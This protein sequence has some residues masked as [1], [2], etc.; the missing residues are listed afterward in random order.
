[1]LEAPEVRGERRRRRAEQGG[2]SRRGDRLQRPDRAQHG[3]V[4]RDDLQP[5]HRPAQEVVREL[6]EDEQPEENVAA[7]RGWDA[8]KVRSRSILLRGRTTW[9]V[10]HMLRRIVL[11]SILI[12]AVAGTA[13]ASGAL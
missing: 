12:V 11:A 4:V 8:H 5:R 10:L 6:P 7:A 9:E 1:R 3:E 13:A 2:Q